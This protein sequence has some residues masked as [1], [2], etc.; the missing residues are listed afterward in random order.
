M[1][2]RNAVNGNG[3]V[4]G[5]IT[6]P[7]DTPEDVWTYLLAAYNPPAK[8][9]FQQIYDRLIQYESAAPRLL[10]EIKT[11][12]TLAGI[13]LA[14]SAQMFTDFQH[15]LSAI[16]EGAFPTAIYMLQNISPSG[17]VTQPMIDD[18]IGRIT[19]KL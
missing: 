12:N 16:R 13:T 10:R 11:S 1:E 6:M 9:V 2:T 5:E 7:D 3:D 8:P 18:M 19:S 4:V 15:V 14:Q 17:F